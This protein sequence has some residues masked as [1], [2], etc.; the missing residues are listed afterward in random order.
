MLFLTY[1][2]NRTAKNTTPSSDLQ[3]LQ[4]C[5]QPVRIELGRVAS[6]TNLFRNSLQILQ[7]G[8]KYIT[9]KFKTQF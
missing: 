7:T 5:S 9:R 3:V 6:L 2:I 1:K 4:T 8:T